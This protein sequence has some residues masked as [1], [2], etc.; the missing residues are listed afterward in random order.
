MA[1]DGLTLVFLF[2]QAEVLSSQN[3]SQFIIYGISSNPDEDTISH[4]AYGTFANDMLHSSLGI[5]FTQQFVSGWAFAKESFQS[6]VEKATSKDGSTT[7]EES[8]TNTVT[9]VV[10][11]ARQIVKNTVSRYKSRN[12]GI[13][14]KSSSV[15]IFQKSGTEIPSSSAATANDSF[16]L[17]IGENE[18]N[19][20][21]F[22]LVNVF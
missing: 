11:G 2:L 13:P 7:N 16:V 18:L 22:L 19:N 20:S 21:I 14:K 1:L 5:Q 8:V 9:Q 3:N 4:E 6:G 17:E 15:D 12:S 10:S